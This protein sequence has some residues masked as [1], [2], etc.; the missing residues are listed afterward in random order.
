MIYDINRTQAEVVVIRK[1]SIYNYINY[2][3]PPVPPL[4]ASNHSYN[5]VIIIGER[6]IKVYCNTESQNQEYLN[7]LNAFFSL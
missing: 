7:S 2:H 4:S 1:H 3:E 5:T 6:H